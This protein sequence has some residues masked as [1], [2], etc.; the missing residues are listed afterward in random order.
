MKVAGQDGE[1]GNA[2][3]EFTV[4]SVLLLVPLAYLVLGV[5]SVQR[6]AFGVTAAT[7]EAGRAYVTTTT[8]DPVARAQAAAA[9][10]LRDQ[11]LTLSA[12]AVR[13]R[14]ETDCRTPGTAVHV[15]LDYTV[16]L[17]VVPQ[18]L[19][20]HSLGGIPVRGRHTELIDEFRPA[21][22]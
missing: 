7:R 16:V 3:I 18:A 15:A 13:I 21:L 9:L 4:L 1:Q 14:C 17:P 11:G 2:L 5:F 22:P 10:A 19:G 8:G 20:G 6:A 12:G